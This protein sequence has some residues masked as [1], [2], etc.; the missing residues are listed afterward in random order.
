MKVNLK[1]A[2]KA[3][4]ESLR[5]M[6]N[7]AMG[8]VLDKTPVTQEMQ[9]AFYRD[10]ILTRKHMVWMVE[11]GNG[12]KEVGYVQAKNAMVLADRQDCEVGIY[13]QPK[14]RGKGLGKMAM[15]AL[16]V[17]LKAL[18]FGEIWLEVLTDNFHAQNLFMRSGF[19]PEHVDRERKV[20]RMRRSL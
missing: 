1:H 19:Q 7:R 8:F 6:R 20:Y 14:F 13:L 18:G 3:D 2:G 12:K 10:K 5:D 17:E 4:M 11:I 9:E 16:F 15:A